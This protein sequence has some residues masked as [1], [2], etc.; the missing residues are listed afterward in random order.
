MRFEDS[1]GVSLLKSAE[2]GF[3]GTTRLV[4]CGV[5]CLAAPFSGLH[6]SGLPLLQLPKTKRARTLARL[7]LCAEPPSRES[8]VRKEA[9]REV[10]VK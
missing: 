8:P 5:S 7:G 9:Y 2:L 3:Q 10:F 1:P 4:P 6:G